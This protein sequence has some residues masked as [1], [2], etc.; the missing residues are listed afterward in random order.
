MGGR[1]PTIKRAEAQ[2]KKSTKKQSA[3]GKA[4]TVAGVLAGAALAGYGL[5][6]R[7]KAGLMLAGAGGAML[8]GGAS[9]VGRN[10]GGVSVTKSISVNRDAAELYEFW[11]D[12]RN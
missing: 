12:V 11:R 6:R 3:A 8:L 10:A 5:R 4:A 7:D 2:M 1:K 9:G